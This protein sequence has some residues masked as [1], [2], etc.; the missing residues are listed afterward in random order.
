[1][2]LRESPGEVGALEIFLVEDNPAD[3]MLLKRALQES[4]I[5]HRVTTVRDGIEAM[6]YL[7][8]EDPYS[9]AKTPHLIVLDLNLP[10]KSGMEVLAELKS[11]PLLKIVPVIVLTSSDSNDDVVRS[12]ALGANAYLKKGSSLESTWELFKTVQH[13]WMGLAVLPTRLEKT[14]L[15]RLQFR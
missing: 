15:R 9:N 14:C 3:A 13:F 10:R 4:P 1:M 11:D 2:D 12:Y 6:R 7:R 8:R 5:S